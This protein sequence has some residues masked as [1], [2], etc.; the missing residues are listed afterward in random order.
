MSFFDKEAEKAKSLEN[1]KPVNKIMEN[2]IKR[3]KDENHRT[4]TG[5]SRMHHRHS[6][7]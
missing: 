4:P 6:R 5:Y 3:V 2:I 7:T 1:V